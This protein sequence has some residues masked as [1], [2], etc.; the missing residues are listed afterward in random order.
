MLALIDNLFPWFGDMLELGGDILLLIIIM[1]AVMWALILERVVFLFWVFPNKQKQ[2]SALW[3]Q[4]EDMAD[5]YT[6]HFR[7]LLVSRVNREMGRNLQLI[8][9]I[10]KVCPLLGLLGTVMGMLEIFDAL[11]VTGNNSARTTAGG[12]S[13]A[14]VSTMAGMVVAISGLMISN[15]LID[16]ATA[17]KLVFQEKLTLD[18][19]QEQN[20]A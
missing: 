7:M 4:R 10:V 2:L 9:T 5:W 11:A 8:G 1:A 16:K 13:K 3:Q 12:V 14:T 19:H 20:N 15:Y 17:M 6:Q 18:K